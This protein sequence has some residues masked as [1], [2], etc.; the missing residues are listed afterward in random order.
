M[1]LF[2]S[3]FS[4]NCQALSKKFTNNERAKMKEIKELMAATELNFCQHCYGFCH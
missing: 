4:L 2:G 3:S 1:Y